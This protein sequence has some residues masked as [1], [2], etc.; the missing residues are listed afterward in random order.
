MT[1]NV[2]KAN[3]VVCLAD[4][5]FM[6]SVNRYEISR[7]MFEKSIFSSDFHRELFHFPAY[8]QIVR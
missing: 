1:A 5:Y 2:P 3:V 7:A 6:V 4:F 8:A